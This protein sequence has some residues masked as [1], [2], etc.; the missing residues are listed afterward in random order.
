VVSSCHNSRPAKPFDR[1][2]NTVVVR[3]HNDTIDIPCLLDLTVDVLYQ[4]LAFYQNYWFSREAGGA[5]SC[6]DDCN[7]GIRLHQTPHL[8]LA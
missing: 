6:G 5:A 3:G 1:L 4:W 7:C 2:P 8:I